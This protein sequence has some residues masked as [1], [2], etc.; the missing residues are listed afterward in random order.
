MRR[1]L[2]IL[3][4][5]LHGCASGGGT[6]MTSERLGGE[7]R[8]VGANLI[9]ATEIAAQDFQNAWQAI[10]SLRPSWPKVP[11][12][13]NNR[14]IQ[15]EYLQDV[16]VASVREIRLL[17]LEQARVRFGPEAQPTILVVTR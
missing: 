5:A 4:F 17:S 11:A 3:A 10:I 12:Y 2:L 14:R 15:F 1:T 9:T 7:A 6:G 16:P 8:A 13:V